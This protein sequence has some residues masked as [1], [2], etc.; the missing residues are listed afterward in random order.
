MPSNVFRAKLT[1]MP[2]DF[3][4]LPGFNQKAKWFSPGASGHATIFADL[5]LAEFVVVHGAVNK[6]K[7]L[8]LGSLFK[9]SHHI[10][11]RHSHA[12]GAF[13]RRSL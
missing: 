8:W 4:K 3:H 13:S 6:V 7:D 12:G 9:M 2:S 5:A 10:L 11:V 1:E